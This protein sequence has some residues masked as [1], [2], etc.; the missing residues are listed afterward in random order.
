MFSDK[1][2]HP[3]SPQDISSPSK[4]TRSDQS[5]SEL[6]HRLQDSDGSGWIWGAVWPVVGGF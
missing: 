2:I 3:N 6:P 1:N 5:N 4:F